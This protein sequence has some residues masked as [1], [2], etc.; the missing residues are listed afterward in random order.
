MEQGEETE[1]LYVIV[2]GK[3]GTFLI[4]I[5]NHSALVCCKQNQNQQWFRV[6]EYTLNKKTTYNI[7]IDSKL[8]T[9][10]SHTMNL[11]AIL[12]QTPLQK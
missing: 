12:Q 5:H 6:H 4:I 2:S 1:Y 9:I 7:Y 3:P 10:N 11:E 8:V